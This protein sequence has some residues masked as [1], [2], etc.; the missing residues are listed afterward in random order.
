M[1]CSSH[2][3]PLCGKRIRKVDPVP[4]LHLL[5]LLL[6]TVT[7]LGPIPD[8]ASAQKFPNSLLKLFQCHVK[9]SEQMPHGAELTRKPGYASGNTK[10]TRRSR[11]CLWH[12]SLSAGGTRTVAEDCCHALRNL[13]W[14][15]R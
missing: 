7:V 1:P 15:G 3:L 4:C 10:I 13:G 11:G 9:L 12:A 2:P 6:T 14:V 8:I 5:S